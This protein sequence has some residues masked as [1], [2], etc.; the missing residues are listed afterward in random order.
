MYVYTQLLIFTPSPRSAQ[1][2]T[3]SC[4]LY[5]SDA[6]MTGARRKRPPSHT[7]FAL[8]GNQ[9]KKYHACFAPWPCHPPYVGFHVLSL[10][11][12]TPSSLLL[13]P[14]DRPR[15]KRNALFVYLVPPPPS[16]TCSR[17]AIKEKQKE[18]IEEHY[19]G[20]LVHDYND[21]PPPQNPPPK[22]APEQ[23][24]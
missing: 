1:H 14:Q 17:P 2:T 22:M 23:T 12:H 9:K 7:V 20:I 5:H 18:R 16:P 8:L 19:N 24:G 13:D 11:L 21:F 3:E 4:V 6:P 15:A 10:I